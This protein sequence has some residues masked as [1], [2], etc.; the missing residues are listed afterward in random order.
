VQ[1]VLPFSS[2]TKRTNGEDVVATEVSLYEF[3][4]SVNSLVELLLEGRYGEEA[5]FTDQA[6]A[7]WC[8]ELLAAI[9]DWLEVRT[10]SVKIGI[11]R[12]VAYA[13]AGQFEADFLN[14]EGRVLDAGLYQSWL[15]RLG[16]S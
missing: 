5:R 6:I 8:Y 2:E 15:A 3:P 11:A 13:V 12:E 7:D 14:A 1:E 4:L 9:D 10:K 16:Q